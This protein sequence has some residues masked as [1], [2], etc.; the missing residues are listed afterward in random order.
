MAETETKPDL[1]RNLSLLCGYAPSIAAVC[2]RLD[3][4]RAQFNKYLAGTTT[5]SRRNLRCICDHFGVSD[6]ELTLP[7]ERFAEI[8][9]LKPRPGSGDRREDA[10]IPPRYPAR[11]LE[12]ASPL[13]ERY[14]GYYFRYFYSNTIANAITRSLV[15]IWEHEG[16]I[17]WKNV[18]ILRRDDSVR[19]GMDTMKYLGEVL[20]LVERLHIVE[21]EIISGHN[22]CYVVLYPNYRN[23]MPWLTGLQ[24]WVSLAPGRVPV[25]TSVTL[26]SLGR[27]I[28]VRKALAACGAFPEDSPD[29]DPA[30]RERL[31]AISRPRDVSFAAAE[32]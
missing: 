27:Q 2:R 23:N 29:I 1:A 12:N 31:H 26:E 3:M 13:Q 8:V 5:P 24:T 20:Y 16:R 17:L 30:V 32:V 6:W 15:R 18:E 4:N 10:S 21:H 19:H 14:F 9:T 7:H 25:A 11:I 28:D 22:L